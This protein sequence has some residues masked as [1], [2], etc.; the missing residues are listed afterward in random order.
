MK[1]YAVKKQIRDIVTRTYGNHKRQHNTLHY[2]TVKHGLT[3]KQAK[4][5]R[6]RDRELSIVP[7]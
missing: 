3:W 4:S 7:E 2:V 6:S 1:T 5:E